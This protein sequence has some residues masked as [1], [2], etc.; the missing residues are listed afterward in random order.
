[1][2]R[3]RF[4]NV[5]L[6]FHF[7]FFLSSYAANKPLISPEPALPE[8]HL[9]VDVS[10]SMKKT[11]PQN[12][13]IKAINM[14]IYLIKQK[15]SMQIQT[16]STDTQ[17]MIPLKTVTESYQ[18]EYKQKSYKIG[19]NGQWTDI[20]TAMNEAN[21]SWGLGKK[22]I[23]LLTDGAVDLGTEFRTTQSKNKLM[24]ST[25]Q[26]LHKNGVTVFTIGF[27][28]DADKALLDNIAL[29]T[30]GISRVVSESKDLDN[31]LYS[32]FTAI[33]PVNGTPI[34]VI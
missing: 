10:G 29:K 31:V 5:V 18:A 11:D 4:L 27:S 28:K 17:L 34:K 6:M 14:F 13:R 8:I 16:F 21:K 20:D 24:E 15:A 2:R 23:I 12:L 25:L 22:N 7:I 26:S 9:L 30:S 19:S 3:L 1:M 33:I 32:I